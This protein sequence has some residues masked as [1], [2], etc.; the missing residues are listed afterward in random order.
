MDV[1]LRS[2]KLHEKNLVEDL[3]QAYLKEFSAFTEVERNADGTFRYPYLE[4][5]W[6]DPARVPFLFRVGTDIVGFALVR[7]EMEP[8]SGQPLS[9]IAEFYIA[10]SLRR[11]G[12]GKAAVIRLLDMFPGNWV[13][14]VLKSNSNGYAFWHPVISDY[15][16]GMFE[17]TSHVTGNREWDRFYFSSNS[18]MDIVPDN[19]FQEF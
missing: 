3:M 17:K 19:G 10:P 16:R 14:E 15:T 2:A 13:V 11:S 4:F 7:N 1:L 8:V 12:L 6:Q 5:Y 18:R 9:H